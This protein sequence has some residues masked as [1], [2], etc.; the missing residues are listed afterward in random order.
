MF[1]ELMPLASIYSFALSRMSLAQRILL[2]TLSRGSDDEVRI[3]VVRAKA[4]PPVYGSLSRTEKVSRT[5]SGFQV[6]VP[7]ARYFPATEL[8]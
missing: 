6:R 4:L 3:N 5:G 7:A 1:Q 2:F 8:G